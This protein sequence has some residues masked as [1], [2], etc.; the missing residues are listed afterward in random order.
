MKRIAFLTALAV[1]SLAG[2]SNACPLL[3][4]LFGGG[5]C[6]GRGQ[7]HAV[8]LPTCSASRVEVPASQVKATVTPVTY[9]TSAVEALPCADGKCAAPSV[10]RGGYFFRR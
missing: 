3:K 7:S 1:A 8:G 10:Q 5:F 6:G 4:S 2:T 9:T